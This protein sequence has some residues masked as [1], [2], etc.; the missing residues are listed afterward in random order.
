MA[1]YEQEKLYMDRLAG[2]GCTV[3]EYV[4]DGQGETESVVGLSHGEEIDEVGDGG[5]EQSTADD[6]EDQQPLLIL[7]DCETTGFSIYTN[8]ITDIAAKVIA[9]PVPVNQ[10]SFSSLVRTPRNIPGPGKTQTMLR[11]ER[12]LSVVLPQFVEWLNS[13]VTHVSDVTSTV[14]YPGK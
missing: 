1:L 9:S 8:H 11:S 2:A 13:A 7:F 14:H 10:P 6:I 4:G 3:G 12:P 5:D